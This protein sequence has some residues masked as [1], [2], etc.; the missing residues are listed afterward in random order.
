MKHYKLPLTREERREL[1]AGE[2]ILL[3]GIIY[4]ARDAAHQKM[5]KEGYPFDITNQTIYYVGPTP[6]RKGN[7]VG[8][9]GPTTAGRMDWCTPQLYDDGLAITIGKGRRSIEVK[10]AIKRN[11][12][13]Y[14]ITVGGA[15]ALLSEKIKKVECVAYPELDSEAVYCF[16][17][18]EFPVFVGIDTTG[19]DIYEEENL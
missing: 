18:E 10:E 3:S 2:E 11:Q 7:I 4:T 19:R 12:A 13:L 6:T 14:L 9:A 16:E 17:V 5:M 1:R 15:G 8:S